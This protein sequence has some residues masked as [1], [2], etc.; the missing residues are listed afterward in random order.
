MNFGL[1]ETQ[2]LLKTSVANLLEKECSTKHVRNMEMDE[3][4]YSPKLWKVMAAQ[5]WLG[6]SIPP[7]H[8]G[9]GMSF[10]ELALVLGEMG[11]VLLPSPFF[12]TVVVAADVIMRAGSERQRREW[13]PQLV[14]GNLLATTAVAEKHGRWDSSGIETIAR[15]RGGNFVLS[16]TKLYVPFGNVADLILIAAKVEDEDNPSFFALPKGAAGLVMSELKTIG[17]ER[18]SVVAIDDAPVD[19][20][21]LLPNAQ[22][23]VNSIDSAMT[24]S[25]VGLCAWAL[26]AMERVLEMTVEYARNRSQFGKPIGQFQTIQ[27]RCADMAL[28]VELARNLT[29]QA[30]QIVA[31][32]QDA[33]REVSMAKSFVGDACKRMTLTAHQVFGAIGFTREHD[34]QLYT[35]RAKGWEPMFGNAA[36]HKEVIANNI[37][38]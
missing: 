19:A 16:G 1:T 29:Y 8:G 26:G 18:L 28:D 6:L 17:S 27:H 24:R 2:Q 14:E 12:A 34:L 3:N 4:G 30:A 25:V 7:Q 37:G 32:E 21:A 9:S 22:N 10:L 38:L 5:G 33:T 36:L 15:R 20:T 13:I 31:L 23:T 35:R 11:R